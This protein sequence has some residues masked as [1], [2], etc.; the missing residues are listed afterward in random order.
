MN[1]P[2]RDCRHLLLIAAALVASVGCQQPEET[3]RRISEQAG[4]L[5]VQGPSGVLLQPKQ[6]EKVLVRGGSQVT[7]VFL[8]PVDPVLHIYLCE[9]E[10]K[11]VSQHTLKDARVRAATSVSR[12]RAIT[13]QRIFVELHINPS[14]ELGADVNLTTGEIACYEGNRFT[15]SSAGD[16]VAYFRDPPHF[17]DPAETESGLW[18]GAQKLADIPVRSGKRIVWGPSDK[19]LVAI[20]GD[21]NKKA[22]HLVVDLT[23]RPPVLHW[24]QDRPANIPGLLGDPR[25]TPPEQRSEPAVLEYGPAVVKLRGLL[26]KQDL[27]ALPSGTMETPETCLFLELDP[28]VAVSQGRD[29]WDVPERDISRVQLH[30]SAA[31]HKVAVAMTGNHV[32]VTGSLFHEHTG[33]HRTKVL[34]S[35]T[36]LSVTEPARRE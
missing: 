19:T 29:E 8:H 4:V 20:I 23:Q 22:T 7:Y 27:P 31:L 28:S 17:G 9:A 11:I 12:C 1:S 35:V 26:T 10:G 34:I 13:P 21:R 16:K 33:H 18:S 6:Y 32:S 5:R 15:P 2:T 25:A 30:L 24:S 36:A 3:S 14:T